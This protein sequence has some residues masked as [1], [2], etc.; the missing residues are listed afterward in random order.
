M[1]W[2]DLFVTTCF[3]IL[4]INSTFRND[5]EMNELKIDESYRKI[6]TDLSVVPP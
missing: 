3:H 6:L 1:I 2:G 5:A 4:S